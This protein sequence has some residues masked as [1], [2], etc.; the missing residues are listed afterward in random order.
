MTD[1]L[2]DCLSICLIAL[3]TL[4][5]GSVAYVPQQAW[6]QNATLRDNIIFG[7]PLLEGKYRK[8]I[9]ACALAPDLDM[10]PA[11]DLTEIGEK[12]SRIL[13]IFPGLEER[14]A[15]ETVHILQSLAHAEESPSRIQVQPV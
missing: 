8:V 15:T 10:L 4:L 14:L 11:G 12:V 2:S 13:Q 3:L 6:I 5:Q 1:L 9:E 7:R